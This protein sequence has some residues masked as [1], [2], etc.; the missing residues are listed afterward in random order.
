MIMI[1][2]VIKIQHTDTIHF[3]HLIRQL[4]CLIKSH[5]ADQ[6]PGGTISRKFRI[7]QIQSPSGLCRI[8]QICGQVIIHFDLIHG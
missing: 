1:F 2:R 4:L 8:R 7:H 6:D 5:I 3:F